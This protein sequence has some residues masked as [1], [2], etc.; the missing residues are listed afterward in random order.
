MLSHSPSKPRSWASTRSGSRS[1]D[2]A[3]TT[4]T[5]PHLWS[6]SRR[7]R[8]RPHGSASARQPSQQDSA[9]RSPSQ[10][11][12]PSSMPSVPDAYNSVSE[13][14]HLLKHLLWEV[15]AM[16]TDSRQCGTRL[17]TPSARSRPGSISL[18]N[19]SDL[20]R[21]RSGSLIECG[22][23]PEARVESRRQHAEN[24]ISSQA[25]GTW[26]PLVRAPRTSV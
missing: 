21:T 5:A 14:D 8:Q 24:C 2:S 19:L 4:A 11:M 9:R 13:V 25:D 26:D 12:R 20:N 18:E 1:T 16:K 17:T 22:S 10:R 7:L 15:S 3:S 23:P 6:C